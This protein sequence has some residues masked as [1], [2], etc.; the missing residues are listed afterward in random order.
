[1]SDAAANRSIVHAAFRRTLHWLIATVVLAALATGA[2]SWLESVRSSPDLLWGLFAVHKSLGV[3]AL[4]LTAVRLAS[5]SWYPLK[6]LAALDRPSIVVSGFVQVAMATTCLA[7]PLTGLLT[8]AFIG[9]GAPFFGIPE[10][11]WKPSAAPALSARF[12]SSHFGLALL[13]CG[14]LFLHVAGGLKHH[15]IDRD[16]TVIAMLRPVS[17]M[18]VSRRIAPYWL[19]AIILVAA[20]AFF[21]QSSGGSRAVSTLAQDETNWTIDHARSKIVIAAEAEGFDISSEFTRF[22]G[23]IRFDPDNPEDAEVV[24]NIETASFVSGFDVVDDRVKGEGWLEAESNPLATWRASG[25][26]LLD[27]GRFLMN[28]V[29]VIGES[30]APV[31]LEFLLEEIDQDGTARASGVGILKRNALGLGSGQDKASEDINVAF[32]FVVQRKEEE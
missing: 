15:T 9:G 3:T 29:L 19:P 24:L 16:S 5:W 20:T 6:R 18:A 27:D 28:G 17:T 21:V 32:D 26:E 30:S 13:L 10:T 11:A 12:A 8:D 25:A 2:A 7:L 1:M 23:A 31:A 22:D 4:V 14:L